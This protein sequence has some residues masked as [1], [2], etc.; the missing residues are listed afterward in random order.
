MSPLVLLSVKLLLFT[1]KS[2][3]VGC[4]VSPTDIATATYWECFNYADGRILCCP[5]RAAIW[6]TLQ[7][8]CC[9]VSSID[10]A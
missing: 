1:N 9:K 6:E 10:I 8:C 2:A 7:H 4:A 5:H 3:N